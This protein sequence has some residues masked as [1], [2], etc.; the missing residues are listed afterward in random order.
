[1]FSK[2]IVFVKMTFVN[3]A[4]QIPW[5]I[6]VVKESY[7]LTNE[8]AWR[9]PSLLRLTIVY[10]HFSHFRAWTSNASCYLTYRWGQWRCFHIFL[11]R[12]QRNKFGQNS[13]S[14]RRF[15]LWNV[16]RYS[17]LT[18]YY[19]LLT[20][21]QKKKKKGRSKLWFS[22]ILLSKCFLQVQKTGI[23]YAVSSLVT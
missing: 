13:N 3:V 1:M 20:I 11:K 17:P 21:Y 4:S 16:D 9:I 12:N 5:L 18:S 6:L 7:V 23:K 15:L 8:L 10:F 22:K 19:L 2:I 14:P